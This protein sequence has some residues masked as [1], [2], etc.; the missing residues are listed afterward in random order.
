M[1]GYSEILNQFYKSGVNRF[2]INAPVIWQYFNLLLKFNFKDVGIDVNCDIAHL[3]SG[4]RHMNKVEN[5]N[6][7]LTLGSTVSCFQTNSP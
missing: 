4:K 5:T 1:E 6:A 7:R 3:I 2:A